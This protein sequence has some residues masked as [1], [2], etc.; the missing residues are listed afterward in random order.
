MTISS[1][2]FLSFSCATRIISSNLGESSYP[3]IRRRQVIS[4]VGLYGING[5]NPSTNG[6]FS[7]GHIYD[8]I[9]LKI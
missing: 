3:K 8:L 4:S 1:R 5:R 9:S 7:V 6:S 2:S